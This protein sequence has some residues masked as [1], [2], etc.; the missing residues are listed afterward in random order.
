VISRYRL[1]IAIFIALTGYSCKEKGGKHINE[2]EIH[3]T[4]EYMG[5][6]SPMHRE[7]MP[8]NLIVSFKKNKIL[9]DIS[10][11][12]G[13][14]GILNLTNPEENIF[15]TYIS[16]FTIKQF[17]S[18][19][20]GEMQPGFDAMKGM[21]I[22]GTSKT[23]VICGFNCKNAEVTLPSNRKKVYNIWYTEEIDVNNPNASTPFSDIDGVLM[24]FFFF[25]G[26]AEMHFDAETVYKK[27]I[28]D[29][30]FERRERYMRVSREDI[31]RFITKMISL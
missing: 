30:A 15:D 19:K 26:P 8:K 27:E 13:N 2:G 23:A 1:F 12:F 3:Y 17:Y 5:N 7:I 20:A 11:P 28:P 4:I 24:S 6:I 9:F 18:S 25:I 22:R 10:S 29:K 14:S 31:T 21:E 16:L